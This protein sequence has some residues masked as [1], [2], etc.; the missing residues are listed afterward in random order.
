[1]ILPMDLGY[2]ALALAFHLEGFQFFMSVASR[3][4][5]SQAKLSGQEFGKPGHW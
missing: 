2:L 5:V 3:V 1:M 4:Q